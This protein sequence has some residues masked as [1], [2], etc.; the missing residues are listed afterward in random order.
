MQNAGIAGLGLNW[1]YF[2]CEVLPADLCAAI[3]GAKAMKF[4]GLNL[5]VP[6]KVPALGMVDVLDGAAKTWGAIN[7]IRFETKAADGDWVPIAGLPPDQTKEIRTHGFNTDADAIVRSLQEDFGLKINGARVLLLGAGGA[8]KVAALK[9][10]AEG[11]ADL[12]LVNRTSVK[13]LEIIGD[14]RQ[15]YPRVNAVAGYPNGLVDLVLNATS[16]GLQADDPLPLDLGQFPL[17][18]TLAVYD[19][20]YRPAETPLLKAAQAAG[21]RIANG[22]GMLLHQGAQALELWSGTPAPLQLMRGALEKDIYH[23]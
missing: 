10:A 9:L 1:R 5:T 19:M 8:G 15:R 18:R 12:F 4:I 16:V 22:L 13:A 3:Q 7:T 11:V 6:H 17:K 20:I 14:I 2:A 23:A 21:C